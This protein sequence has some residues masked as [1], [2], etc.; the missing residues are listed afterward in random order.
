MPVTAFV[1]HE[2]ASLHD[3]GWS[4]SDH[5]G[6]LPAIVRAVQRDMAALWE[7][8][9]QLEAVPATDDDLLLVH[10]A[11][12]LARVAARAAEAAAAGRTLELNGVPV[13]GASWDAA[14]ASV[15]AALVA[16]DAVLRGDVR[17]AFALTRPP[18]AGARPDSAAGHAL[19]NTAAILARWLAERR[20]VERVLLLAWGDA[21]PDAL[22]EALGDDARIRLASVHRG[23]LEDG[24]DGAA[25]ALAQHEALGDRPADFVVLSAGFDIL[26]GDPEGGLGVAPDEVHA[27]TAQLRDWAEAHADGRIVSVL[28]GGY[29]AAATARAVVQH[30]RALGG[31]EAA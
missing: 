11:G 22:R 17:S 1:S 5:Q 15:G 23:R 20:G 13:S 12:H 27:L 9:M 10:T 29:D 2:N 25:L 4:H 18:G 19:L 21:P 24:A 3:T 30:L 26:A 28:E 14:V 31:V 7:P 6:R 8:L 16:A